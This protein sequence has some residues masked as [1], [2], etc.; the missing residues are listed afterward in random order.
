MNKKALV[1][2][3]VILGVIFIIIAIVYWVTSAGALPSFMP[4]YQA[5]SST[6]HF[7]HGLGSLILGLVLLAY[8]WF[9]SG[10]KPATP[11]APATP[12]DTTGSAGAAN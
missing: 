11:A 7:K 12:A 1:Y 9:K 6:V 2:G 3:S 5:G 4:G 8:A 10:K